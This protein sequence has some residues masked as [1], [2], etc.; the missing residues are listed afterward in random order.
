MNTRP[1]THL[2]EEN[3]D[4]HITRSHLMYGRN[5]NRR[6]A[7]DDN[8]NVITLDK[9]SKLVLNTLLLFQTIF[10]V[11]FIKNIFYHYMKNIVIIKAIQKKKKREL[12]I[13]DVVLVQDDKNCKR[14]KVTIGKG[15][16]KKNW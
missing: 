16:K 12:K 1:L 9:N 5:I 15:E 2:S 7:V 3:F 4:E 11:D 8:N 10:G 6:N 14:R 13:N